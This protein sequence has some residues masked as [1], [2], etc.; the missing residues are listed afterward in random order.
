MKHPKEVNRRGFLKGLALGTGGAVAWQLARPVGAGLAGAPAAAN[1]CVPSTGGAGILGA[2]DFAYLGYYDVIVSSLNSPYAQALTHRYVDGDLRF[3]TMEY[4]QPLANVGEWSIAGKNFGDGVNTT[5]NRWLTPWNNDQQMS[6]NYYGLWWDEPN[7]R[8]WSTHAVD[9]TYDYIQTQIFTRTL[10]SNGTVSNL[11]GPVGLK[12]IS[13]KRTYGGALQL[14]AWFQSRYRVGPYAV[15][16]GGYTS[17]MAGGGGCSLGPSM[18]AIPDPSLHANNTEIAT[19]NFKTIMDCN[20][21]VRMDDWYAQGSP[22]AFDRGIRLNIPINYYDQGDARAN[23]T[24]APTVPPVAGAGWLSPAP[25]GRARWVWG[26][27][28]YNTGC[29][30]DG[31]TKQGYI[32]IATLSTGKT[33][34]GNAH[35]NADSKVF[36]LHV[37]DPQH[38]GEVVTGGRQP[39]QVRPSVMV[40]LTLPGLGSGAQAG[41]V[42]FAVAGATYDPTTK[43]LY[44]M[45]TCA[46]G[47]YVNRLFVYSVN[48]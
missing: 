3:L 8:L 16:F 21:G 41:G 5:T 35:L 30:I 1:L 34:Y 22:T 2:A 25:D 27:S 11:K 15:G 40:P 46:G 42:F 26:D 13:A 36:E 48:A 45:G 38:M 17:L 43:R 44:L 12:G 20:S 6:G 33:W 29:W 18:Y 31:P 28:Y 7:Q 37:Y 19:S 4:G 14:P 39:W 24:T 9:Y 10:N 47:T 32:A 23:P